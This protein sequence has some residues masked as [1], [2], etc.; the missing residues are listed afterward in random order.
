MT[1]RNKT[2]FYWQIGINGV[3]NYVDGIEWI[4]RRSKQAILFEI[5]PVNPLKRPTRLVVYLKDG[6]IFTALFLTYEAASQFVIQS[7]FNHS[8]KEIHST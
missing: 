4:T 8:N 6:L 5:Y 1:K 7:K 2:N 3:R